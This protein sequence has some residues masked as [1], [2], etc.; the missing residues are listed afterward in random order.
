MKKLMI[1]ILIS[2]LSTITYAGN[3][4]NC[5][6]KFVG[7]SYKFQSK[8]SCNVYFNENITDKQPGSCAANSDNRM[9]I[10]ITKDA[11]KAMLSIALAARSSGQKVTAY[12]SNTCDVIT[13]YETIDLLYMGDVH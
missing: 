10:D 8:E 4:L 13:P 12:G 5:T 1:A 9:A 7:C 6:V 11:V 3:C 2:T